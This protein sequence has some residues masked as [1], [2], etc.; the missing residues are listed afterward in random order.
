MSALF[1]HLTSLVTALVSHVVGYFTH[2]INVTVHP[3]TYMAVLLV[4]FLAFTYATAILAVL[5]NAEK[6]N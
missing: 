5:A 1:A 3:G 2:L 4:L 6:G